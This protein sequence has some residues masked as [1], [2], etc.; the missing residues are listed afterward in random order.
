VLWL[1]GL[2]GSGKSTLAAGLVRELQET[3]FGAFNLDG[4]HLRQGLC[5]DLQ[6]SPEDRAENIRR[7]GEVAALLAGAG[8]MVV[9]SLISPY[10]A[11]R[12]LARAC[13]VRDG[14]RFAEVFVDAP[15]EVCRERDPRGLYR[16][17][18]AG[19]I[20]DFTGVSAPYERPESPDL[21]INTA[22][23]PLDESLRQLLALAL[24]MA[25]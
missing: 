11:G 24:R 2:P 16:R 7:A 13:C 22:E 3:G 6:F 19:E 21:T 1:T 10:A 25:A 15:V 18:E 4:D 23:L 8:L 17:A 5:S 14:L 20:R 12:K 9:C